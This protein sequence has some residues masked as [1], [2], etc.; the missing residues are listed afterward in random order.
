VSPIAEPAYPGQGLQGRFM[1]ATAEGG[2]GT[3][4]RLPGATGEAVVSGM[5]RALRVL[6]WGGRLFIVV[7]ALM[8]IYDTARAPEGQR[9]RTFAREGGGFVG[10]LA[11]GATA[12]LACG[13]GALFCSVVL[14]LGFGIA[15]YFAGRAIGEA[16][17]DAATE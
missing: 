11:L 13:P 2:E 3:F 14:G 7:G 8:V 10:G 6:K 1:Q 5:P 4:A 12:G 17:Y 16:A 15:G 9:A